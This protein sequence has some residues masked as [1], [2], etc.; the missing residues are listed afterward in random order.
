MTKNRYVGC[1]HYM[2]TKSYIGITSYIYR[3]WIVYVE[4][5]KSEHAL[6]APRFWFVG[7]VN[8]REAAAGDF[9]FALAA[10]AQRPTT[11]RTLPI[12]LPNMMN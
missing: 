12:R 4:P 6:S 2:D 8:A 1:K 3:V 11:A 7:K 5:R 10:V 9:D